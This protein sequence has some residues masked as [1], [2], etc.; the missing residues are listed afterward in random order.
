M[1]KLQDFKIGNIKIELDDK[2]N[3]YPGLLYNYNCYYYY[4]CKQY[5]NNESGFIRLP[6]INIVE[7]IIGSEYCIQFLLLWPR[8]EIDFL[9]TMFFQT[10][11]SLNRLKF[12]SLEEFK[13]E[14]NSFLCTAC[15]L[16]IFN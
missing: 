14:V 3:T 15:Q 7:Q 16:Y 8:P 1:K 4:I 9:E 2:V 10:Y 11:G 13:I 6:A 12:A 5:V